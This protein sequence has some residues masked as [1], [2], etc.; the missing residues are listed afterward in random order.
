[1][2]LTGFRWLF[3]MPVGG[4]WLLAIITALYRPSVWFLS[5]TSLALVLITAAAIPTLTGQSRGIRRA[6]AARRSASRRRRSSRRR[7]AAWAP[8]LLAMILFKKFGQH[9]PLN[10]QS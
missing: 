5:L 10:R 6:G 8:S 4:Y 2:H 9:Q 3:L 7:G 1:K